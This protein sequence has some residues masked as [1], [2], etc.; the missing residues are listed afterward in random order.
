MHLLQ[1]QMTQKR[2]QIV[3]LPGLRV[4]ER[5]LNRQYWQRA[6]EA[7]RN[8]SWRVEIYWASIVSPDVGVLDKLCM[9]GAMRLSKKL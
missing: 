3:A 5:E 2:R 6:D 4:R 1:F 8:C 7:G 9:F